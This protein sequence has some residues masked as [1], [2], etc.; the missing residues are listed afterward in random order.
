MLYLGTAGSEEM[1][2]KAQKKH[3]HPL[4]NGKLCVMIAIH[5]VI[6]CPSMDI[7]SNMDILPHVEANVKCLIA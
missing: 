3:S 6:V 1:R 5:T 2:K 7:R 4:T